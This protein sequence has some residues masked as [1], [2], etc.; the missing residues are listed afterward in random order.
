MSVAEIRLLTRRET[1][2]RTLTLV[3]VVGGLLATDPGEET[4]QVSDEC[5]CHTQR[6]KLTY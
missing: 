2:V 4:F 3:C 5:E 1:L 6:H